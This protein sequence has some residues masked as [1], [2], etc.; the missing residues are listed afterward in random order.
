[1]GVCVGVGTS[2]GVA[3]GPR[4]G[5]GVGSGVGVSVGVGVCVGV[6]VAVAPRVG[7]G[8]GVASAQATKS[9]ARIAMRSPT[10]E[11]LIT[12]LALNIVSLLFQVLSVSPYQASKSSTNHIVLAARYCGKLQTLLLIGRRLSSSSSLTV[13]ANLGI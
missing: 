7:M 5:V 4:V 13:Y 2:V 10:M 8:V 3:V 6:G 12:E 1:M 9:I 11:G